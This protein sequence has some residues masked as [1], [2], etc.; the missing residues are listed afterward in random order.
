MAMKKS[1]KKSEYE[2]HILIAQTA[3][4]WLKDFGLPIEINSRAYDV[5]S[6]PSKSVKDWANKYES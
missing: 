5:M 2:R 4:D 6:N 1:R 3:V